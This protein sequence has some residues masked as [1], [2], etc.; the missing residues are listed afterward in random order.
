[1]DL[2]K[3]TT[4]LGTISKS[5]LENFKILI[6][7]NKTLIDNLQPIFNEIEELQ[8]EIKELN[9]NY[10]NQLKELRKEAIVNVNDIISIEEDINNEFLD[11]LKECNGGK[12]I[13]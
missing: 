10:N 3:Y 9:E 1:M 5:S 7:K 12:Q 13:D 8:K 4:S 2:A 11:S 6:P